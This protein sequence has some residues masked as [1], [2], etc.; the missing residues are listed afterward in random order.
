M[1]DSLWFAEGFTSY[2]GDL[3]VLR[4]GESSIGDF[5]AAM[6]TWLNQ[7]INS[8]GRNFATPKGMSMQATFVDAAS[9]IDPTNFA[10]N[11]NGVSNTFISYYP[12]GAA[13][14]LALD[15]SMRSEFDDLNLD[16]LMQYMWQSYGKD[17]KAYS[18]N[19]IR[20]ALASVTGSESFAAQFF[21]RYIDDSQL[22]DFEALLAK[23]GMVMRKAN[24]GAAWAG[25]VT[26]AFDDDEATIGTNSIIGTPLYEA[27]LDRG[28]RVVAVGG[29]R[30]D[31]QRDWDRA[32]E[33][34]D[35]GDTATIRYLQRGIKLT[36]DIVF[37]E[38][39]ALEVAPLETLAY[40]PSPAQLAFRSAWLGDDQ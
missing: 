27:G 38:D 36:A 25:P 16:A 7:V 33:R 2:Y 6:S 20:A 15:L 5:S 29:R 30:I 35:P 17:E 12:Y 4:A 11:L 34:A 32:I 8:P 1:T 14:A 9:S 19:D 37:V 18:S 28:D 26:F 24:S 10:S 39:P 13:I 21:E 23:A 22:P 40:D 31:S 3:A